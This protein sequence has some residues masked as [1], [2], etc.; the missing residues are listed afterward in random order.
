MLPASL[1]GVLDR[2]GLA[3]FRVG[4][5]RAA[6]EFNDELERLGDGIEVA[7]DDFPWRSQAQRL[8]EEMF[9]SHGWILHDTVLARPAFKASYRRAPSHR[10]V[11]LAR[12]L[13]S[14][15][16]AQR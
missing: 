2:T 8:S 5:A 3:G 4:K 14:L 1:D 13:T 7:S 15:G 12:E 6:L 11:T 16:K 9:N 10:K